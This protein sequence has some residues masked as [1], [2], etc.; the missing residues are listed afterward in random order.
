MLIITVLLK[1]SHRGPLP[2]HPSGLRGVWG[3]LL[4]A[5]GCRFGEEIGVFKEAA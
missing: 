1:F 5:Q 4:E 3:Q 2:L